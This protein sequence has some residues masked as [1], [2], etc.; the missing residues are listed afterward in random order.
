M[1]INSYQFIDINMSNT[2]IWEVKYLLF[3]PIF[4]LSLVVML[5][6]KNLMLERPMSLKNNVTIPHSLFGKMLELN[7][8]LTEGICQKPKIF[9]QTKM[10]N[11]KLNKG[12]LSIRVC[13][14]ENL[15]PRSLIPLP[16]DLDALVEK[17]KTYSITVLRLAECS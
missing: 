13:L 9:V 5:H 4:M 2:I 1:I 7:I 15:T 17:T 16:P 12:N 14:Y 10:R 3:F 11:G 6:P 8:N